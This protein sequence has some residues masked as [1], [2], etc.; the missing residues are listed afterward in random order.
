[1]RRLDRVL[2]WAVPTL[3]GI[4]IALCAVYAAKKGVLSLNWL[5]SNKDALSAANSIIATIVLL[6]GGLIGY[7]RF[8]RGRT[9]TSRVELSLSADVV[10]SPESRFLHSVTVSVKNIGTIAILS[11]RPFLQV[12]TWQGDAPRASDPIECTWQDTAADKHSKHRIW[13]KYRFFGIDPG[14]TADFCH[15]QF[16]PHEVWAVSYAA[17]ITSGNS[18]WAKK[19]TIKSGTTDNGADA[20]D[21]SP[22]L[23]VKHRKWRD[24]ARSY[25]HW[26]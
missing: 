2:I 25:L 6:A 21:K 11:P 4:L 23:S 3:L 16:F 12:T 10:E 14:E 26:R 15:E 19:K 18:V 1:M 8:F 20:A 5:K 24:V 9:L 13:R 17:S 22:M 7:L